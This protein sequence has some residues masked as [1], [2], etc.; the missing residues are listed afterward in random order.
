MRG[1]SFQD[2]NAEIEPKV[3]VN[4]LFSAQQPPADDGVAASTVSMGAAEKMELY[5]RQEMALQLEKSIESIPA[6]QNYFDLGLTSLVI[7]HLVQKTSRLLQE[8]LSP[9][10]LLEYSDIRG[11]ASHLAATYPARIDALAVVRRSGSQA[12]STGQRKTQPARL[13]RLPRKP[14]W[15][16]RSAPAAQ[17]QTTAAP[18]RAGVSPEQVLANVRWQKAATDEAYD[19]MTF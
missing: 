10:A 16:V 14:V 17:E 11:V 15:S 19:T 1:L 2:A 7:A 18:S 4:W 5:L 6:D 9:S 3:D 12:H 13:T 8:D